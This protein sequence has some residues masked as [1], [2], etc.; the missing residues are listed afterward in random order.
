MMETLFELRSDTGLCQLFDFFHEAYD[1]MEELI[2]RGKYSAEQLY[3][4][5]VV[6]E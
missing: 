4:T 1:A 3:I 5:R 6:T 2:D